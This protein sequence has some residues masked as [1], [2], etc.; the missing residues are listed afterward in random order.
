MKKL[1]SILLMIL[2]AGCGGSSTVTQ[3]DITIVGTADL[4]G[5]M[6]S[7]TVDID[8]DND[9]VKEQHSMGGMG[10]I[11][12]II[13]N[14]IKA[15]PDTIAVSTGDDLMGE[16][17]HQ[18]KGKAIFSLMSS[19]GYRFYAFG[20]HEFDKGSD[21]LSAALDN[22]SFTPLCTDLDVSASALNGKCK[23]YIITETKGVKI[24]FF[25]LMTEEFPYITLENKV[26]FI[27]DNIE[28]AKKTVK[29]LKD[30]GADIIIA[31]THIGEE[32][33]INLAKNVNGINLIFGG[34][35][36]KYI[37]SP[38][39]V[40][41]TIIVNGGEK[42]VYVVK[43]ILSL[44]ENRKLNIQ[45]SKVTL[46]PVY[47]AVNADTSVE[48]RIALY[49]KMLPPAIVLGK[50]LKDWN[51]T[52]EEIRY[53]ESNVADMINDL[54]KDQ[55]NVD[56]VLNNSGAFR[57]KKIYPSGD[58]TDKMLQEIDEFS[59]YAYIFKLKGKY[60]KEV[61][62]HSAASYG[63]GA[64]LQVSGIKFE[65]NL[66]ALPQIIENDAIIQKG[67]RVTNIKVFDNNTW[68]ELDMEK[69]YSLLS[70][71]YL[72]SHSGD[73]YFWFKKY[74]TDFKNTYTTFYSIM[75][76]YLQKHGELTPPK[77]DG[78]ITIKK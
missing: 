66:N 76:T 8:L 78:R 12:T 37:T 26:K 18:F 52:V 51:L 7:S 43:V 25:S 35:S 58:I 49:E 40:N 33:D 24:G 50:T 4:Q 75:E 28:T 5:L 2:L 41:N 47:E 56:I 69:T 46:L 63:S 64:F 1:I 3:T 62:E 14:A 22:A 54:F 21:I 23:P 16:F 45:K 77:K 11:A 67:E 57:G 65:I 38:L 61:L 6:T 53:N 17:F 68:K 48:S 15:D 60:I 20:N 55:F 9:S 73:K 36:H 70:N 34:H 71:D 13:K 30:K 32:N 19:T 27:G 59:N 29:L 10:R 31:L 74:G 44:D 39:H 42:G 72:V